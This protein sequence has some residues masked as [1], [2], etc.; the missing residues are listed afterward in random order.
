MKLNK[1]VCIR[2]MMLLT[3]LALLIQK[4]VMRAGAD[5]HVSVNS[6]LISIR[7]A[8][9]LSNGLLVEASM[10][11]VIPENVSIVFNPECLNFNA[12]D[13]TLLISYD[14]RVSGD[15]LV[16][17][18]DFKENTVTSN[19]EL[20]K[21]IQMLT[22]FTIGLIILIL[23]VFSSK[24]RKN[25]S[26]AIEESK[27]HSHGSTIDEE[28]LLL[29]SYKDPEAY[30]KAIDMI[31]KGELKVKKKRLGKMLSKIKKIVNLR[32]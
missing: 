1:H 28:S 24:I 20:L 4:P 2:L 13:S 32:R 11:N 16:N 19:E 3:L 12:Q 22:V 10:D 29:L 17:S 18:V 30:R 14:A 9:L 23:E 31:L 5:F 26:R 7:I 27:S 15:A 6:T 8:G 25:S 21:C